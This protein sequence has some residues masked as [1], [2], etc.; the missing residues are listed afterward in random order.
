MIVLIPMR[1]GEEVMRMTPDRRW[2]SMYVNHAPFI[3]DSHSRSGDVNRG[4][5][6]GDFENSC[7]TSWFP[8]LDGTVL[9]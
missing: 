5:S 1:S 9:H 6:S 3:R 2:E 7:S 4:R 8:N